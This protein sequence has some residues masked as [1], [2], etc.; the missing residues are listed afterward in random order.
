M[1]AVSRLPAG[2]RLLG[3]RSVPSSP[4]SRRSDAA[5]GAD[6]AR[7]LKWS[8]PPR[9]EFVCGVLQH[10]R[11]AEDLSARVRWSAEHPGHFWMRK[12]RAPA[13]SEINSAGCLFRVCRAGPGRPRSWTWSGPPS[14][15]AATPEQVDPALR[16]A[17][18][19]RSLSAELQ[20]VVRRELPGEG[21]QV[22]GCMEVTPRPRRVAVNNDAH[23]F[24]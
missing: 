23:S 13:W 7:I 10:R 8:R 17:L 21:R 1:S 14:D 22:I 18:A 19:H 9:L 5:L 2:A 20:R 12:F 24:F 6:A 15:S 4:V 16:P 11:S 3:S